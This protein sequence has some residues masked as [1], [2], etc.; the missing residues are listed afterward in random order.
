MLE[1]DKDA[2]VGCQMCVKVC[3]HAVFA[4]REKKASIAHADRCIECGAC[5]LNCR[6]DAIK[7][8]K[9]V[10]CLTIIIRQDILKM[11]PEKCTCCRD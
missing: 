5:R 7:V 11:K 8:T 10:G 9:G 6:Y 1:L 2:C 4:M 3:P